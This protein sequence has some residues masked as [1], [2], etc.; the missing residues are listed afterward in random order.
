MNGCISEIRAVHDNLLVSLPL[1]MLI[2]LVLALP[3]F[4]QGEAES[5]AMLIR[6]TTSFPPYEVVEGTLTGWDRES[7]VLDVLEPD[8]LRGS[9]VSFRRS[10]IE[11]LE[12]HRGSHSRARKGA[13]IGGG[14][15]L[16]AGAVL[17]A[18]VGSQWPDAPEPK[19]LTGAAYLG[20][21]GLA[22]GAAVGAMIGALTRVHV[23]EESTLDGSPFSL[24]PRQPNGLTFRVA[25]GVR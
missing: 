4:G 2:G 24:S 7:L 13:L 23:W 25:I 17:G 16:G 20:G 1:S 15:G 5:N 11:K 14:V 6:I 3:A 10:R 9:G 22:A 8:R 12:I 19:A 18:I 21:V